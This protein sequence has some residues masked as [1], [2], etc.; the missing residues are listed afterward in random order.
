MKKTNIVWVTALLG[1]FFI[2]F[3]SVPAQAAISSTLEVGEVRTTGKQVVLPVTLHKTNYLTSL[4]TT[5]S[6]SANDGSVIVESFEP[7]GIF[8]GSTFNTI[9]TIKNNELKLDILTTTGAAQRLTEDVTIIGYITISLSSD[10]TEG[11][12]VAVTIDALSAKG[13]QSKDITLE[14]LNGKIEHQIPFGDVLDQNQPTA[15]GA[16]R[17]LQHIKGNTIDEQAAFLAADVDGDG[18]LTQMDA[19]HILDFITGKRSNFLAVKAKELDSAVLNNEY[20]ASFEGIHGREPYKYAKISGLLP[21]GITIINATTGELTGK[22]TKAGTYTFTIRVTDALDRKADRQFT[23][24]V[25]DSNIKSVEVV[26]PVN[27]KL[28]ETPILPTEVAVTYSDNT[29]GKEKVVWDKVDTTKLGK[30]IVKG[31]V[32][33]SGFK[34]SVEVHVVNQDYIYNT[35]IGYTQF[36]NIHTIVLNVAPS[37]YNITI[38]NVAANYD[39]NNQFS[40]VTTSFT[41]DATVVIRLYDRFGNILETKQQLLVPN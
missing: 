37:V 40:L 20:T 29:T 3:S 34:I 31:T 35:K 16:M 26:S 32:G 19:Q 11:K 4:Q 41:K 28:N 5:L 13:S 14:K 39:G 7:N 2:L 24:E 15:A 27:V 25:I 22:P 10:F 6:L 30:F 23:I 9:H 18:T 1:M 12:E 38:N 21:T 33:N 8:A 17:I 36:L